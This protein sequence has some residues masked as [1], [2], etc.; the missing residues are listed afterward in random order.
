MSKQTENPFMHYIETGQIDFSEGHLKLFDQ[1]MVMFPTTTYV[2]FHKKLVALGEKGRR[3][4]Y[5]IGWEQIKAVFSVFEKQYKITEMDRE[6]FTNLFAPTIKT[7]GWGDVKIEQM[8]FEKGEE[9]IYVIAN[10]PFA[11]LYKKIHGQ[12]EKGVD[13]YLLGLFAGGTYSLCGK[14]VSAKETKCIAKGDQRCEFIVK[15][16]E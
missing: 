1:S 6:R 7:C 2:N 11:Q 5:D 16:I 13:D 15:I 8:K 12:Q 9:T 14:K 10:N 4:I 3:L